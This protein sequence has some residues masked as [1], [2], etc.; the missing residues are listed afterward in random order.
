MAFGQFIHALSF[1]TFLF[2]NRVQAL[3]SVTAL[4]FNN[5]LSMAV[6]TGSGQVR[7]T[8]VLKMSVC[9]IPSC[10][11]INMVFTAQ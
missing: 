7:E 11:S 8:L 5:S 1:V 10:V 6:G 3:P 2:V 9:L 4:K